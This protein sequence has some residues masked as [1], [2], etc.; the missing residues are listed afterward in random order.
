MTQFEVLHLRSPGE[1][2][3][4]AAPWDDL[5]QRSGVTLPTARAALVAHWVERLAPQRRFHA[6]AVES[7]GRWLAA[8]PLIEPRLRR[9]V[10][11]GR[12][13]CNEWSWAGDLLFDPNATPEALDRLIDA[14]VELSL[15]LLWFDGVPLAQPHWRRFLDALERRGIAYERHERF[16]IGLVDLTRDWAAY[17]A[18]WSGNFRRQ[19]RKMTRR[20]D[21]LGGV[22]LSVHRPT[23][24]AEL[25]RLLQLGFEIEDR[26]WKGRDGTSVLKSP[27]M[28]EYL[29]EQAALLAELGHLELFFLEFEGQSIAFEYGMLSK[30]TY[31]SPKV[32]YDEAYSHLSPGQLLRLKMM[33]QFFGDPMRNTWDFLG[34]LVEAP[35]RWTTSAYAIERLV[36]ATGGISGRLALRAYRDW[37]PALRR[38][39]D[40]GLRRAETRNGNS[41]AV[42]NTPA[43]IS[44]H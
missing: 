29:H 41:E 16:R 44:A 33:E 23:G 40:H 24:A 18:A 9:V 6:L 12:L 39:R 21:E 20:A 25:E 15:P 28:H 27:Q 10:K 31:F 1:V 11:V 7:D 37:W 34:P 36:V 32:G 2:R 13:P 17:Q 8:L 35:D 42:E 30:R 19:M 26:S 4:S 43:S 38:L 14:I 3:E 22:A 5:W